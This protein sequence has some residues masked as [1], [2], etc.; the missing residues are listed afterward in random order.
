MFIVVIVRMVHCHVVI[1]LE[2]IM[3]KQLWF[4][5]DLG[6]K[7]VFL[8]QLGGVAPL[9][10]AAALPGEEG[11][12]ITELL[13]HST[14]DPDVRAEDEDDMYMQDRVCRHKVCVATTIIH[15]GEELRK[16]LDFCNVESVRAGRQA[17]TFPVEK[18]TGSKSGP[19]FTLGSV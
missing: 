19:L 12:K 8:F 9:H 1:S 10:I 7:I 2:S 15:I 5:M 17:A 16:A 3:L 11:I 13:L 4:V 14:A 18:L 6:V